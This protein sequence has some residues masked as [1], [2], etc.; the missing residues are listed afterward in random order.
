I[1]Y[2][3]NVIIS[4]GTGSGKCLTP[5]SKISL[6]D[7]TLRD[8]EEVVESDL[9]NKEEIEDGW[10]AD[11]D[12]KLFSMDEDNN[13]GGRKAEKVWKREAPDEMFRI[14]TGSGRSIEATAEHPF[15]VNQEGRIEKLRAD[16]I[17]EGD[18]IPSP[19]SI[20]V[21]NS[22]QELEVDDWISEKGFSRTNDG[23][24][25]LVRGKA[26]DLPE[27]VDNELAE[28]A[29]LVIGDGHIHE[30]GKGSC[31]L[32][33]H[34]SNSSVRERFKE[35]VHQLFDVETSTENR[36]SRVSKSYIHSHV[37]TRF[38][39]EVLDVPSGEKSGKIRIPIRLILTTQTRT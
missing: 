34:N 24:I 20:E 4:G 23:K 35:S 6:S 5:G 16:Q 9:D 21:D 7:G 30:N 22:D 37:L 13:V 32:E 15:F 8:I 11:S 38:F 1:Q 26:I 36:E 33:L 17:D 14:K 12:V 39:S 29:G 18:H 28:V 2:E 27:K 25:K 3:M 10:K 19:R 31:R